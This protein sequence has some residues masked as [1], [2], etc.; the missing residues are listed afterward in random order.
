[1]IRRLVFFMLKMLAIFF[2]LMVL[3]INLA[4]CALNKF[5]DYTN[6]IDVSS[7]SFLDSNIINYDKIQEYLSKVGIDI[8][9]TDIEQ[10]VLD[11]LYRYF[12]KEEVDEL[13]R[14]I[15]ENAAEVEGRDISKYTECIE[16]LYGKILELIDN[17]DVAYIDKEVLIS[18][19]K[20]ADIS[21]LQNEEMLNR[22]RE[23][24]I[25]N[26]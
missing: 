20:G 2:I 7:E 24:Q 11:I 18:F 14:N 15:K 26:Q 16:K 10:K 9:N 12:D 21:E 5:I 19:L 17:S 4:G 8:K 6:E 23:L 1:M 22:L 3:V 25:T 13:V